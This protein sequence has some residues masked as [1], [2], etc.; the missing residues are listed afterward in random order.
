MQD[1]ILSTLNFFLIMIIRKIAV[2]DNY[3]V[4]K[5]I[6]EVF[7]EFNAPKQGTVYA[8]AATDN[9]FDLFKKPKSV[10]WVLEIDNKI[11]G[12]CG[13]YPTNGLDAE[14]AELVKLYLSKNARGKGFGKLMLQ[15]SIQSAK[16]FG[17]KYLYLE[18]LQQFSNAVN[19][20]EKQGFKKINY[21]L[22]NSGH[23]SCNIWMLKELD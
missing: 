6:R 16:Q 13:I 14:Y 20:Y 8:D 7:D 5:M 11:E 2:E 10:F 9:L 19:M 18:S 1:Y 12:C 15:K 17:Y 22:G 3:A 21:P 23:C 4:A